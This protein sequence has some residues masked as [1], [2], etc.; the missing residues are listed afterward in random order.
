[1]NRHT[2]LSLLTC[3]TVV[4]ILQWPS[5]LEAQDSC[6]PVFD[7]LNRVVTTPSHSYST[8]TM[9]GRT[10][11]GEK[12]Y[13]QGKA[14][15]LEDG[16]WVKDSDDLKE[17]LAKENEGR[18]HSTATCKIVREESVNGRPATLYSLHSKTEHAT[19]E[20]QIWIAKGPGLA[21]REEMDIDAGG[22]ARKSHMSAR[23]EYGNIQ[24]PI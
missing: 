20:A 8:Y 7:A 4:V 11:A 19:E 12:I 14:F 18:A 5:T 23:F 13:T 3:L 9:Q 6:Q 16:K 22:S 24:P 17:I 10:I 1:M 2:I 21:L 15:D